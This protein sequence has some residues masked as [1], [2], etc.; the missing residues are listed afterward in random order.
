[1]SFYCFYVSVLCLFACSSLSRLSHRES[2][3]LLRLLGTKILF[4]VFFFF[5]RALYIY[6]II[7]SL[8][9]FDNDIGKWLTS[10]WITV[11]EEIFQ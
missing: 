7:M 11:W 10:A 3:N 5:T 6:M 9:H 8:Y 2:Q 4:L 1:M